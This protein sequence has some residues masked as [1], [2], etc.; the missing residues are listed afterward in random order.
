MNEKE[1]IVLEGS[2]MIKIEDI[3]KVTFGLPE[4][5]YQKTLHEARLRETQQK[6]KK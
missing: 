5:I 2:V 6:E 3:P 4:D 1:D